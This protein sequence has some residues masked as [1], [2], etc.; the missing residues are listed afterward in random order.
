MLKTFSKGGIHPAENKFSAG[1]IIEKLSLPSSVT[2]PISQHIGAPATVLVK[3]GDTVK[4]GQIIAQSS[5]FVSANIHSSVTGTVSKIDEIFDASGYRRPAVVIEVS[6]DE[7]AD[8]IDNSDTLVTEINLTAK[9]IIQRIEAAGLVG[10]GGATFPSHVKLAVPAGKKVEYL[11]ING[12]E[13][14][15]YLTADHALMLEKGEEII[16]GVRLLMKA[17][18]VSKAFIGIENNK[19]DAIKNLSK[20]AAQ[21][22]G[23]LVQALKTKYPQGGEKQLIKATIGREVPSGRLPLDVEAVVF[24]VG[25]AF[26]VYEAVQKNKPLIER[27]V[28]ITGKNVTKPSNFKVRIGTPISLL[29][30]SAGGVPDQTGKIINGGPMMGK[31]IFNLS[32]PVTKGTSGIIMIPESEST[33]KPIQVCIRCAKCVGVCP[34]GLEPNLLMAKSTKQQYEELGEERILDCVECGSCSFI[35]PANRPLLD[36]IR[37]GKSNLNRII[38]SRKTN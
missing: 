17:L 24:N 14:E 35:C 26:A 36:Y 10:L 21:Y 12:A 15:P 8:G 23:L 11:I 6:P 5:G 4:T 28:T 22:S 27:I 30:E 34:M 2:I 19:P 3:R 29:I 16:T 37:L 38:R 18:G 31:A 7:W 25:S 33:R 13:C 1:K 32:T 20:I 9:E